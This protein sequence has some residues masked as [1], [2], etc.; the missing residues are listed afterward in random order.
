MASMMEKRRVC[1]K[2]RELSKPMVT[3]ETAVEAAVVAVIAGAGA[4]IEMLTRLPEF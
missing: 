2:D 4:T 1:V 3:V